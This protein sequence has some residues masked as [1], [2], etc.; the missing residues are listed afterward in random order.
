[1][2]DYINEIQVSL[3]VSDFTCDVSQISNILGVR[4]THIWKKSPKAIALHEPNC[5]M[6][7]ITKYNI[8]YVE[9]MIDALVDIFENRIENFKQ[10][11]KGCIFEI[12]ITCFFKRGMSSI[13]FNK[14]AIDF[15]HTIGAEVYVDLYGK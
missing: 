7:K 12:F 14:R 1:M 3:K 4:S 11:P 5:W 8:I 2:K 6:H 10:L 13:T 9:K 15:I